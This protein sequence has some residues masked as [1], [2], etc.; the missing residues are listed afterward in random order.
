M[1]NFSR[2]ILSAT[3]ALLLVAEQLMTGVLA[4]SDL[5]SV[6]GEATDPAPVVASAD[7]GTTAS[8]D[9]A[10]DADTTADAG[11][12]A[13]STDADAA[14]TTADQA[15]TTTGAAADS[16]DADTTTADIADQTDVA[17]GATTDTADTADQD[18]A[19]DTADQADTTT[20]ADTVLDGADD[21]LLTPL[22][23][24]TPLFS[25]MTR[26]AQGGSVKVDVAT[27]TAAGETPRTEYR[28]GEQ[29][30]TNAVIDNSGLGATLNARGRITLPKKYLS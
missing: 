5:G 20:G 16:A 19:T 29:I 23:A 12:A 13:D 6:D 9:T 15:D 3:L 2:K 24:T 26:A 17:T 1:T 10:T 27:R 22:A 25:M 14:D 7:A 28:V 18:T 11:D 8:D 4:F 30:E 21:A